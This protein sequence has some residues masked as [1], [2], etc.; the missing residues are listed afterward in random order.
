[1]Q[2]VSMRHFPGLI[3]A[4]FVLAASSALAD[5]YHDLPGV[6]DPATMKKRQ[7]ERDCTSQL[8]RQKPTSPTYRRNG[9]AYRTYYCEYGRVTVGSSREPDIIEYRKFKEHY[10]D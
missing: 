8:E 1:M 6:K 7:I 2:G 5:P 9:L 4:A 3:C 10:R